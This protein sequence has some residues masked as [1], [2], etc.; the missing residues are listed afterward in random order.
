MSLYSLFSNSVDSA[1]RK[2]AVAVR[3]LEVA[4]AKHRANA[5]FH[6]DLANKHIDQGKTEA[7]A[8]DRARRVRVKIA[9]LID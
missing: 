3:A 8:A 7:D 2:L 1:V 5:E 6:N 4:E 9:D